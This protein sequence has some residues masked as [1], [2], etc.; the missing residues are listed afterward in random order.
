MDPL[1]V[2]KIVG[3]MHAHLEDGFASVD[4]AAE[5]VA[6]YL[7]H[8]NTPR[9][10]EGLRRSLRRW[11]DGRYRWHW[12]PNFIR[13]VVTTRGERRFERLEEA[14]AR[15]KLPVQLIRGR[16]SELVRPEAAEAFL[17]VVPHAQF[18]DISGAGH[19]VA[20]DKNDAFTS[21]VRA[22]L[23]GLEREENP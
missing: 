21:A 12:D 9:S 1:G 17:Q 4:E 8:R 16:M 20:G 10:S 7:P 23:E 2:M 22:F 19:M 5:A 3:F 6:T 18:D 14:A 15:L 11:P 13:N